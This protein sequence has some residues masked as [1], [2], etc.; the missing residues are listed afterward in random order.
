MGCYNE[1]NILV[2]VYW[3]NSKLPSKWEIV[4]QSRV[5]CWVSQLPSTLEIVKWTVNWVRILGRVYSWVS[6]LAEHTGSVNYPVYWVRML[7]RVYWEEYTRLV[8]WAEY[9]AGLVN[10]VGIWFPLCRSVATMATQALP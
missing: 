7:G 9:T 10:P 5:Y 1:R 8:Y 2:R 3:V 6:I 4:D